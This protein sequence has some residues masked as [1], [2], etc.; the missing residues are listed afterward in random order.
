MSVCQCCETII[1]QL[2]AF[3]QINKVVH[4][5]CGEAVDLQKG[6]ETERESEEKG[7]EGHAGFCTPR[8]VPRCVAFDGLTV[9]STC[10]CK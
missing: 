2:A 7:P 8:E 3:Y 6:K 4:Y 1:D 5:F 9:K 10:D